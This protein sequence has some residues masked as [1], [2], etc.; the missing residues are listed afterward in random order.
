MKLTLF[1]ILA[2]ITAIPL[3]AQQNQL[4]INP[5]FDEGTNG[6]W[7]SGA[8]VTTSNGETFFD[9]SNGG[10][11]PWDVQ[12]GQGNFT[13][14]QGYK[15]TLSW[16]AKRESGALEFRVAL[17]SEPYT[18]YIYDKREDFNGNWQ[19][20]SV[21]YIHNEA[22]IS[23]MNVTLQMGG[24]D[25]NAT[26]DYIYLTE[27]PVTTEKIKVTFQVD[28]QNETVSEKGVFINGSF[29]NWQTPIKMQSDGTNYFVKLLLDNGTKVEYKYLNGDTFETVSEN[30][31]T[32][33]Y[34]NRSFT[35]PESDY[36][37]DVVC[38]NSCF[39]CANPSLPDTNP[40]VGP[41]SYYGQMQASG[42]RII[43]ER[44]Q[45]PV[46]AK[47]MSFY[48]SLWGGE[49]FWT[50]GVVNSLVDYFNVEL[51]RAPMTV[52]EEFNNLGGYLHEEWKETQIAYVETLVDAAIARD[53]YVII[54]YH[55]HYA[56]THPENAKEFFAYMAQKYGQYD[57]V[58]FE[59]YN[60]PID[61]DWP[62]IKTYAETVIDTIRQY[63]DNL[64]LV[65]TEFYSSKVY[66]ASLS[67]ITD[68]NTA[69]VFHFYA[70]D[71][72]SETFQ[73]DV[74]AAIENN[75]AVFASEW[76]NIYPWGDKN[77]LTD[78]FGFQQSDEWHV[79]LDN[80][81]I[82]SAN[83]CVLSTN[84][85]HDNPNEAAIFNNE[86][87]SISRT[88]EH[89]NDTSL[90]TPSGLYVYNLFK[91]QAKV[92][93]WRQAE[94]TSTVKVTFNVN[95][96]D[97]TVAAQG[98]FLE[99]S[100][101]NWESPVE[102]TAD[103]EVYSAT[104]ELPV[105]DYIEY[106]FKNGTSLEAGE[107]GDCYTWDK[108][109]L[110]IVP[111]TDVSLE[112]LCFNSC[113]ECVIIET[114]VIDAQ[115]SPAAGGAVSGTGTYENGATV[116]L[117]ATPGEGYTFV[118]WTSNGDEI[119]ADET[120]TFS[121]TENVNVQANF[122]LIPEIFNVE[123]I[124]SPANAGE[125]SGTGTFEK[126]TEATLIATPGEG[127]EFLN[128]TID[129]EE[130][131]ADSIFTVNVAENLNLQA[132]FKLVTGV[133]YLRSF[134]GNIQ[135]FPNP[136]K[137]SIRIKGLPATNML[138]EIYNSQGRLILEKYSNGAPTKQI[139]LEKMTSG[140][141]YLVIK[142]TSLLKPIKIVKIE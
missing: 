123:A 8:T 69:Y 10:T 46:Q 97:E 23:G 3:F 115:T 15:Y 9:I 132:N 12:L 75:I 2:F 117:T 6:W 49:E 112:T 38:F 51:I 130:V 7:Y 84:M 87:G 89:W 11:N 19:K 140:V 39:S 98:V 100:F 42:N 14:R 93:P 68:D 128:W 118:N 45:A 52:D 88:G 79:I 139:E 25:A 125:I 121:A 136:V 103:N 85:S 86:F 99:G 26:V 107:N 72:G 44:T 116:S 120:L 5:D 77:G 95:M 74:I 65:G 101:N 29:S 142:G 127:Y 78:D 67:P 63:S 56:D 114:F 61:T 57:N 90:L 91:E 62:T 13:L 40:G 27:E 24:S 122:E 135:V 109:R 76:G 82:S 124:L 92:A 70:N 18:T 129:G 108:N 94:H 126:G 37:I 80:Y 137:N 53:I 31:T 32:G 16:R 60:E 73:N 47:G 71:Y 43:G 81:S 22:D 110:V 30:C 28:M 102:M 64:V 35:V 134:D 131:S 59:I 105:G 20:S 111:E 17:G 96:Y 138:L 119:S 1:I 50:E 141:Y 41:V 48:W 54:D 34:N 55:S 104:I 33:D 83:W 113:A 133:D 106:R 21:E 36:V 66:N 4:L 58:I